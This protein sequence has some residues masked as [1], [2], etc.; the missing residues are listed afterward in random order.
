MTVEALARIEGVS[1]RFTPELTAWWVAQEPDVLLDIEDHGEE[2]GFLTV[3][4]M[5]MGIGEEALTTLLGQAA[6]LQAAFF[7]A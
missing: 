2:G 4:R 7:P 6:R 1:K 3:A 5:G